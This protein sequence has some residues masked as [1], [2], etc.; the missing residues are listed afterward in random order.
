[1]SAC[2]SRRDSFL[3]LTSGICDFCFRMC[4]FVTILTGVSPSSKMPED[5]RYRKELTDKVL[6]SLFPARRSILLPDHYFAFR[7]P[8]N[9]SATQ[10]RF[11]LTGG[12]L[13]MRGTWAY[14]RNYDICKFK[15]TPSPSMDCILPVTGSFATYNCKLSYGKPVMETFNITAAVTPYPQEWNNPAD[16]SGYFTLTSPYGPSLVRQGKIPPSQARG[17]F[18]IPMLLPF[19]MKNFIHH[20][21]LIAFGLILVEQ[22]L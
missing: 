8:F 14:R 2:G 10:Y 3:A 12:K 11:N 16:V 13:Y 19:R 4:I 20:P 17:N 5:E 9:A 15:R 22:V 6:Q 1:M 18:V 7:N 21:I